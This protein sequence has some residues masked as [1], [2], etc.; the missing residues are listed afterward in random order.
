MPEAKP[1]AINDPCAMPHA[2]VLAAHGAHLASAARPLAY[3]VASQARDEPLRAC[4]L[5]PWALDA[6]PPARDGPP[7]AYHRRRVALHRPSL[8]PHLAEHLLTLHH[9]WQR[10]VRHSCALPLRPRWRL[11]PL[12]RASSV[13]TPPSTPTLEREE[14]SLMNEIGR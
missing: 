7:V 2:A 11:W 8:A 6:L 9:F 3:H 10:G 4:P 1:P 13:L 5:R 12:R 14:V